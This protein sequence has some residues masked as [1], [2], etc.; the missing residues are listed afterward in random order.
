MRTNILIFIG[1]L[2]FLMSGCSFQQIAVSL[3]L[4]LV[5]GQVRSIQEENDLVLAEN[6]IPASLKMMEGFLQS[7]PNN[8][9]L[10]VNLAEGFC[11]YTF[12]FVEES[13]PIRAVALYERGRD[14]AF[15][16]L[17]NQRY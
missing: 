14:Y 16:A 5:E 9:Q 6:S 12:S 2:V 3:S 13:D 1:L 7:D 17:E 11:G 8:P 4:P 15:L 10:L